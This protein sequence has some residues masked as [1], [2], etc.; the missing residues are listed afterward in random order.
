MKRSI[1]TI[2]TVCYEARQ[3]F[4]FYPEDL[5][6]DLLVELYGEYNPTLDDVPLFVGRALRSFPQGACGVAS[7]YLKHLLDDAGNVVHGNYNGIG[8]TFLALCEVKL[9]A[10]ITADQFEGP[11]LYVGPIMSPWSAQA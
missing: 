6:F 7:L 1:E 11:A 3:T 2:E 8:H 4:E 10:D 5:P 9:L